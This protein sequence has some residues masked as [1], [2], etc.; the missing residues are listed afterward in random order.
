MP[1]EKPRH[2]HE[3]AGSRQPRS[4]GY[5]T[6]IS[7]ACIGEL[8]VRLRAGCL[9]LDIDAAIDRGVLAFRLFSTLRIDRVDGG[10]QFLLRLP[11]PRSPAPVSPASNRG[12][13]PTVSGQISP[14]VAAALLSKPR[15]LLTSWQ[16]AK[17]DALNEVYPDFLRMRSLVMSFRGILHAG[18]LATLARWRIS[19][20][21]TPLQCDPFAV[22]E[23]A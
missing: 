14:L 2:N 18:K 23:P 15:D 5:R 8:K 19:R 17:V 20:N 10:H 22:A 21:F 13:H 7:Q 11:K 12:T 1:H 4:T 3:F 9:H 6:S 16:A